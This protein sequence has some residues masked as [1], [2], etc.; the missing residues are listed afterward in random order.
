[1]SFFKGLGERIHAIIKARAT[2]GPALKLTPKDW[3]DIADG[4]IFFFPDRKDGYISDLT[5]KELLDIVTG[6]VPLICVGN[7]DDALLLGDGYTE[8]FEG[9][10]DHFS[11][12]WYQRDRKNPN[13]DS[14]CDSDSVE[15]HLCIVVE[16][17]S[18]A[19]IDHSS[20]HI[21]N[22]PPTQPS[23]ITDVKD[24]S[25]T[26]SEPQQEVWDPDLDFL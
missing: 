9:F 19:L 4:E 8:I 10:T 23:C 13:Y 12:N 17:I 20:S 1:M 11:D 7:G 21:A 16:G 18:A 26:M 24:V 5:D 6:D 22:H 25:G 15:G 14:G 2:Y 3:W